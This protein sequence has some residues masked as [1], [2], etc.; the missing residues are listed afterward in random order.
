[1]AF[2]NWTPVLA[3]G[4]ARI[5]DD[6]RTLVDAVNRLHAAMKAGQGKA[7]IGKILVFLRD[8][9]VTHFKM[10]EHLM[11][12]HNYPGAMAHRAIHK[13]L[14]LQVAELV[15][16]LESGQAVL[17]MAVLD[18][19]EKWLQTHI[20]QEDKVFATFLRLKGVAA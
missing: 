13:D 8:Y 14:V 19:L 18:F 2:M 10:E 17:T 5:D 15:Q 3:T 4:H 9:T 1:M 6:H 16:K 11:G 7:E 12:L 20:C